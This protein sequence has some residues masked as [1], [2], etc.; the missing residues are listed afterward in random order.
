LIIIGSRALFSR[1]DDIESK[2]RLENADYD[3]IMSYAEFSSWS[4]KN[5][6]IIKEL[7]PKNSYKY[8]ALILINE[9]KVLFEIELG[10]D[11]HS[12]SFLMNNIDDVTDL[13]YVD[14][15]GFT[16]KCLKPEYLMLTKKSHVFFPVHFDKNI[17]DYHYLKKMLGD[18]KITDNMAEYFKL[19]K[20][21]A[22]IRFKDKHSIPKLN[23]TNDDFFKVSG[24]SDG[25]IYIH[26]DLHY[27]VKHHDVPVYEMM[28][29]KEN[30]NMAW[31]EKDLFFN[32]PYSHRIKAVQE[33]AYVISL[34]RYII[35][36]IG[37][38]ND[39][40]WCYKRSLMRICTTLCSGF[41]REFAIENYNN[42]VENFSEEFY[43]KFTLAIK[44]KKLLPMK[45]VIAL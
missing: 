3:V 36:Q 21:E 26:D 43:S 31:C 12:S 34:E 42:I 16:W 38:Y 1:F 33:E 24:V 17:N 18:F 22:N 5:K 9:K 25:R 44:N 19:R 32:L 6:N 10:E 45:H 35:P 28:K 27:V 30:S 8:R 15:L 2:K 23:I 14:P 29:S 20:H 41:F 4:K 40:L 7:V 13:D 37:E 39:L 11:G